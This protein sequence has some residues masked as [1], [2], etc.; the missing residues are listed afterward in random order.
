VA[1]PRISRHRRLLFLISFFG[2]S[3]SSYASEPMDLL[4]ATIEE[5]AAEGY[6]HIECFCPRCRAVLRVYGPSWMEE[7]GA[8]RS[9]CHFGL[10]LA[11]TVRGEPDVA[12]A[13]R[14]TQHR[15]A[16]SARQF[17]AFSTS[18]IVFRYAFGETTGVTRNKEP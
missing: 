5:F 15:R 4:R 13:K 10:A 9:P 8:G 6:T 17:S 12:D 2:P 3:L 16:C 11:S 14:L 18:R 7:P 1:N